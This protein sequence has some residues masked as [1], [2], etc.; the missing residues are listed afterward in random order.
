MNRP[1]PAVQTWIPH[2]LVI[3]GLLSDERPRQSRGPGVPFLPDTPALAFNRKISGRFR[4]FPFTDILRQPCCKPRANLAQASRKLLSEFLFHPGLSHAPWCLLCTAAGRRSDLQLPLV[5]AQ[6]GPGD[7]S[8][9]SRCILAAELPDKR[10]QSLCCRCSRLAG[11]SWGHAC[12]SSQQPRRSF[13]GTAACRRYLPI[14]RLRRLLSSVCC[15]CCNKTRS[16]RELWPAFACLRPCCAVAAIAVNSP[17]ATAPPLM[18]LP[19]GFPL[20]ML[21]VA[22]GMPHC[23]SAL[24]CSGAQGTA[25]PCP[26]ALS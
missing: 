16:P 5:A 14:F 2:A 1:C 23:P 20:G 25:C 10:L 26:S 17:C 8:A 13:Q 7:Q 6:S 3:V 21:H 9:P 12:P 24:E 15:L 4:G 18:L 11:F 22:R 19:P